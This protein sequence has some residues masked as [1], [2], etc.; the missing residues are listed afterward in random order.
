MGIQS[1]ASNKTF[2]HST[3]LAV[4][5]NVTIQRYRA[6]ITFKCHKY[7]KKI[8]INMNYKEYKEI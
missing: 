5:I 6:Q 3:E 2:G 4:F 1:Q 7:G 8:T